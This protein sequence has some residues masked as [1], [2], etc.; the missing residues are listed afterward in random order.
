MAE[1]ATPTVP[2]LNADQARIVYENRLRA[3]ARLRQQAQAQKARYRGRNAGAEPAP[4]SIGPNA[5]LRSVPSTSRNAQLRPGEVRIVGS[6][7]NVARG[8]GGGGAADDPN[9]PLQR[10]KSLGNYIEF[11]LSKLHNSKGGFLVDEEDAPGSAKS[12]DDLRKE[13]ERERQRM[14]PYLEPGISLDKETRPTCEVCGSPEI[15]E[16]PFRK[17]FGIDVCKRCERERPEVYSL[18]TKTEV[19]E[20]YLLTDAE[21]RDEEILPHLLKANPHKATYSNM[22]LFC[23]KQVEAFAFSDAKWGSEDNLD[24]EFERREEEK[25]RKRGKKFQQG[26][27]DLRKRTRDNVWQRR[28]DEE[29]HHEWE[30]VEDRGHTKQRCKECGHEIEVEVF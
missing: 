8:G 29:H 14:K 7:G 13:K 3:R 21:L 27:A 17:V 12:L 2:Q 22:M 4:A 28:K 10:D 24:R 23:R 30:E 5:D 18:L 15:I 19:K 20:D 16:L 26:L 1:A 25:V 6:K 11:D 9:A